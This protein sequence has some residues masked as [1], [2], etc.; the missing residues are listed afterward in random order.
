MQNKT[1]LERRAWVDSVDKY[2]ERRAV[3]VCMGL[4]VVLGVIIGLSI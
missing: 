1:D 2:N 4:L 3:I